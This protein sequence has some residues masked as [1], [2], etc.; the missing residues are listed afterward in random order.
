MILWIIIILYVLRYAE[1]TIPLICLLL[2]VLYII[3][4]LN[5]N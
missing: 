4:K 1:I 2:L 5:G 3:Y